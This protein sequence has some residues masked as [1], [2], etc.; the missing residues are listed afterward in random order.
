M[1]KS[2][3]SGGR[4]GVEGREGREGGRGG[5][6]REGD[7]ER[8]I[9]FAKYINEGKD[10]QLSLSMVA[11]CFT[12]TNGGSLSLSSFP[13]PLLPSVAASVLQDR[14]RPFARLF[15]CLL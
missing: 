13:P 11:M 8:K 15:S 7:N 2:G 14:E 6:G 10:L 1:G 3:G 4:G 5:E 9:I 12:C